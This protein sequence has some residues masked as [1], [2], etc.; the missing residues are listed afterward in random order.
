[1]NINVE[2]EAIAV[3]LGYCHIHQDVRASAMESYYLAS[4]GRVDLDMANMVSNMLHVA[5]R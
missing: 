1:M 3:G 2:A 4:S 5:R